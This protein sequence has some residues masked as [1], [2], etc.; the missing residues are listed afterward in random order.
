MKKYSHF[1]RLENF[2]AAWVPDHIM[3]MMTIRFEGK[4]EA[5]KSAEAL[6]DMWS[7]VRFY[8]SGGS[9][10]QRDGVSESEAFR[11]RASKLDLDQ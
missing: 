11:R 5:A 4:D 6:K 3:P 8:S 7:G 1:K 2:R 10:L 9:V